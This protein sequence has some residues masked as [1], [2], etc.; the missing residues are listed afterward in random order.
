MILNLKNLNK[1]VRYNKFKMETLNNILQM[2][3]QGCYQTS[4]DFDSAYF[5]V[6]IHPD[7]QKYLKFKWRGV[8]YMYVVMPFGLA[9][10]PRIFTKLLKPPLAWLR[11]R[12]AIMNMYIDDSWEI[13]SS[14]DEC[15][16]YTEMIYNM[17][18]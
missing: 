14:Y 13:G 7:F 8:L 5:T 3:Q 17:F 12:G 4:I 11:A 9:S 16:F 6:P 15:L 1:Y 2:V 18:C 10:A